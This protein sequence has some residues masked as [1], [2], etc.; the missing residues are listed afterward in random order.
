MGSHASI[1]LDENNRA[2]LLNREDGNSKIFAKGSRENVMSGVVQ[3][4][5]CCTSK[6]FFLGIK[7]PDSGYGIAVMI[8]I[9]A[10]VEKVEY[11]TFKVKKGISVNKKVVPVFGA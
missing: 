1:L 2:P 4:C 8:E 10:I 3:V 9:V 6:S 11:E 7:N 5:N